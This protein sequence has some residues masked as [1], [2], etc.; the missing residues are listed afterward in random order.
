M[1]IRSLSA[2]FQSN[3]Y[4]ELTRTAFKNLLFVFPNVICIVDPRVPSNLVQTKRV[5]F[6]YLSTIFGR[7]TRSVLSKWKAA[8][9]TY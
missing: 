9:K 3:D 2:I 6:K 7:V 1:S 5:P 8:D 4:N